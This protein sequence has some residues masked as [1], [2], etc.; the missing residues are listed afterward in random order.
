M[1]RHSGPRG[2]RTLSGLR[3][4]RNGRCWGE[5]VAGLADSAAALSNAL[6]AASLQSDQWLRGWIDPVGQEFQQS[7]WQPVE[8]QTEATVRAMVALAE[9][10][11]AA[12]GHVK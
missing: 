12:H 10:I 4:G 9:A 3:D 11:R 7:C 8:T 2:H 6:K 5:T 1:G